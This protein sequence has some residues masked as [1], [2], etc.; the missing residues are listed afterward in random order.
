M[1]EML[2][3]FCFQNFMQGLSWGLG[4]ALALAVVLWAFR[5]R[6]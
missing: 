2:F 1:L 6:L 5:A 3:W 4:V